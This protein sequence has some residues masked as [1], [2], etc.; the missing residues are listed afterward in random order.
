MQPAQA[1]GPG[2]PSGG[3][4]QLKRWGP[5]VGVLAVVLIGLIVIVATSGGG[6]DGDAAPTTASRRRA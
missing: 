6:G 5:L 3:S 2:G 1:S 4:R